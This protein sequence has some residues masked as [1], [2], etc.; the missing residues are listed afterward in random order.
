[1]R[2]GRGRLGFLHKLD[3]AGLD[4]YI[5]VSMGIIIMRHLHWGWLNRGRCFSRSLSQVLIHGRQ[6]CSR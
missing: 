3:M 1:M 6:R 2:L 5:V 4:N